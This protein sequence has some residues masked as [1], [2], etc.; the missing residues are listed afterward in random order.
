MLNEYFVEIADHD[1]P[2]RV[3]AEGYHEDG[4]FI[5]FIK[6]DPVTG[7]RRTVASF[8][9]MKVWSVVEQSRMG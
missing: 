5:N 2:T 1:I 6:K 9:K 4:S 8:N 7:K 3:L